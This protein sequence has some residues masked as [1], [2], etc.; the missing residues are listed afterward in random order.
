MEYKAACFSITSMSKS[1]V[2]NVVLFV[3]DGSQILPEIIGVSK[4]NYANS[5]RVS[6]DRDSEWI[7][8]SLYK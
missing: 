1:C 6:R 4:Q 7:H 3:P 8:K 2:G 5:L